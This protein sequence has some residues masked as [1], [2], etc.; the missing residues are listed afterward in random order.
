MAYQQDRPSTR[1]EENSI[2]DKS[3]KSGQKQAKEKAAADAK[4][5]EDGLHAD[6]LAVAHVVAA[7]H[8]VHAVALK[9]QN[10]IHHPYQG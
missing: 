4:E 6:E 9:V 3:D 1:E 7:D 5:I 8:N 10:P 2:N